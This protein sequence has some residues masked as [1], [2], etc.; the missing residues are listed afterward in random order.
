MNLQ[1]IIETIGFIKLKK[2]YKVTYKNNKIET[3]IANIMMKIK[4]LKVIGYTKATTTENYI[5]ERR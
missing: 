3:E 1:N 4:C 2:K 5:V